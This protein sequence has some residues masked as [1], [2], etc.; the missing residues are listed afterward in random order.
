MVS[1]C[2]IELVLGDDYVEEFGDEFRRTSERMYKYARNE[3]KRII[4]QNVKE[5]ERYITI[6]DEIQLCL[7]TKQFHACYYANNHQPMNYVN[8]K[9]VKYYNNVMLSFLSNVI[10]TTE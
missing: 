9:D 4:Q 7:D 1:Y 10:T 5:N 6:D 2:K 8:N 3:K